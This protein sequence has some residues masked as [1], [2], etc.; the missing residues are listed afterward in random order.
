MV[1][2][3]L[4]WIGVIA[5]LGACGDDSSPAA[6]ETSSAGTTGDGP[7]STSSGG[8]DPASTS[9]GADGSTSSP[10]T[11]TGASESSGGDTTG[12]AADPGCPEC[13]VLAD[14][15]EDG[16]GIAVDATH[17]YFT[18]TSAGTILRASIAGGEV[19][20]LV[21]GQ[22]AP[23][24]LAVDGEAVYWTNFAEAGSVQRVAKDGGAPELV[25]T[26]TPFPRAVALDATHVYWTGFTSDSGLL[27]RRPLT[28]DGSAQTLLSG[29]AGFAEL[30]V[31]SQS[32]YVSSH[33]P[34]TEGGVGFIEPPPEDMLGAIVSVP[35]DGGDE[36]ESL[37]LVA[38]PF[39]IA[40]AGD[41]TLVW[42]T[43]DGAA[44]DGPQRIFR[45]ELAAPPEE[46]LTPAQTAPW[47]VAAD[48]ESVY[49]TDHTEVKSV[50][51]AGG[52]IVVLATMQDS[53]RSIAV[54]SDSIYWITQTRVLARP[55]P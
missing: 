30:V 13:T 46:Q 17:V 31:G 52:D 27:V 11:T 12:G 49:F 51:V 44:A 45:L 32:V 4:R 25:D 10:A 39:G 33:D 34:T 35:I 18:D 21:M 40:L 3:G 14:D 6:D 24:D 43:G 36:P 8:S 53:A 28:L 50:P 20:T 22:A 19:D 47:G 48:E 15:L 1:E 38:Q 55:K 42:A 9:S 5:M 23:Y 37:A 54:T 26:N 16:R 41:G 29:S 7:G 2:R